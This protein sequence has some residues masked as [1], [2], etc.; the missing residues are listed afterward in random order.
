M[1]DGGTSDQ[2]SRYT[3]LL[4]YDITSSPATLTGEWA[5]PLPQTNGQGK[6]LAASELHFVSPTVFLVLTRDGKGHGNDDTESKHKNIDL[7]DISSATDIHGT[8]FDD[9]STPISPGG[10]LDSSI[11][12]AGYFAFVD[13]INSTQLARFGLHNGDP[14]D[15]TLIDAKWESIA[16]APVG[17]DAFP[18]DYFLFTA[19]RVNPSPLLNGKLMKHFV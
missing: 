7:I 2:T 18:D 5:V 1:Q 19:V 13:L 12:P 17:D 9:A 4:S 8:K 11:T 10:T 15:D 16:L 3:R 14:A 6:T